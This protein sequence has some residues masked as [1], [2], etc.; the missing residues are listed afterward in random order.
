MAEVEQVTAAI[1]VRLP[2]RANW[3]MSV[4]EQTSKGQDWQGLVKELAAVEGLPVTISLTFLLE[5]GRRGGTG[6]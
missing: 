6:L 5:F 2:E 4:G 3:S 1:M